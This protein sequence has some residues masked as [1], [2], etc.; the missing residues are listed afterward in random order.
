MA[1]FILVH[2]LGSGFKDYFEVIIRLINVDM[3]KKIWIPPPAP[4][5]HLE[6]TLIGDDHSLRL[7]ETY[8]ELV[9]KL[10]AAGAVIVDK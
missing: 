4:D 10:K 9:E 2:E 5:A 3:I 1:S 7:N 8:D 6:L